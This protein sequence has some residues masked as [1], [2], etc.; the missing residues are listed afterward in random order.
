MPGAHA[1]ED[2]ACPEVPGEIQFDSKGLSLSGDCVAGSGK[3][4]DVSRVFDALE[5]LSGEVRV[6]PK[7]FEGDVQRSGRATIY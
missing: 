7:Q 5:R 4:I 6:L 1:S 3:A 2:A